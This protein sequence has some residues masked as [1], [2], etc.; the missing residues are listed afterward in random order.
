[1]S[2]HMVATLQHYVPRGTAD[3]DENA[4]HVGRMILRSAALIEQKGDQDLITIK[5]QVTAAQLD[6][7]WRGRGASR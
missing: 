6:A 3:S 1:M 7:S 4:L 5:V 2:D